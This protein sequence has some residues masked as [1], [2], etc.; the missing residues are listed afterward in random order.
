LLK[1][2]S[3]PEAQGHLR[4][5]AQDFDESTNSVRIELVKLY[6]AG[7]IVAKQDGQKVLYSPN[8]HN[9]FY[10]ELCGMVSKHMGFDQLIERVLD[11]VGEIN[12]AFV[13]GDY[14]KGLDTG[15]I[16][17]AIVGKVD[18]DYLER[19]TRR[20]EEEINRRVKINV[21]EDEASFEVRGFVNVLKLIGK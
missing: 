9:P 3:H 11:Q 12:A 6:E 15:M 2:F 1:L 8:I 4:G 10:K 5:F 19:L 18:R 14:A 20:A 17:L 13:L 7:F 16:E 21:F